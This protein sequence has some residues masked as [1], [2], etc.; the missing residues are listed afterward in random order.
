M[1]PHHGLLTL[2]A[3][4]TL[5]LS[6]DLTSLAIALPSIQ[7]SLNL[8]VG[9]AAWAQNAY[10]GALAVGLPLLAAGA[11][12]VGR[13][14]G[15]RVGLVLFFLGAAIGTVAADGSVLI[16]A[17]AIQGCGAAALVGLGIALLASTLEGAQ[18]SRAVGIVSAASAV[19]LA[20]G[21]AAAGFLV[22]VAGWRGLLG[23]EAAMALLLLAVGFANLRSRREVR[24]RAVDPLGAVVASAGIAAL[25]VGI[26]AMH[27]G[28]IPVA[29]VGCAAVFLAALVVFL[30]RERSASRPILPLRLVRQHRFRVALVTGLLSY[31]GVS[32]LFFYISVTVQQD[33]KWSAVAAGLLILPITAGIAWGSLKATTV[34]QRRGIRFGMSLGYSMCALGIIFTLPIGLGL[35]GT[36]ALVVGG[37]VSGIGMGLGSPSALTLGLGAAAPDES[38]IASSWLWIARQVGTSVG[39][40]AM[41]LIVSNFSVPITGVR[42]M[43]TVSAILVAACAVAALTLPLQDGA[44]RTIRNRGTGSVS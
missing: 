19:G 6:F 42:V 7:Q 26:H 30:W 31:A 3:G 11:G 34:Q 14:S 18:L 20:A 29:A 38:A 17:R 24:E 4:G 23:V 25:V 12:L 37:F 15:Y 5:L 2:V 33:L 9:Q 27:P 32:A 8:S 35:I 21:P 44:S 36:L 16:V 13:I 1:R 28:G 39:F 40:A 10:S 22:D 41:A 43:F